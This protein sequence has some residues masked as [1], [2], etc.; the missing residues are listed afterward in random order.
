MVK[1]YIIFIPTLILFM[2]VKFDVIQREAVD[3]YALFSTL[4]LTFYRVKSIIFIGFLVSITLFQ[5]VATDILLNV[6]SLSIYPII[7]IGILKTH[8]TENFQ[9]FM[10]FLSMYIF[11]WTLFDLI[12]H[13]YVEG[14]DRY[15]GPFTSSLH[16]SYVCVSISI[17]LAG[18]KTTASTLSGAMIILSAAISGSRVALVGSLVPFMMSKLFNSSIFSKLLSTLLIIT[19]IVILSQFITIRGFI[20]LPEAE[21]I[22]ISGWIK[23]YNYLLE[24]DLTQYIYGNGRASYGAVG[25]RFFGDK[26]FITESSF[27]MLLYCYGVLFGLLLSSYF[28]YKLVTLDTFLLVKIMILGFFL[29]TP[30]ID[31][32]AILCLNA[33]LLSNVGRHYK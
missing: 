27:I 3:F 13:N 32:V 19:G 5:I 1:I 15:S 9:K 24:A 17:V 16:L 4:L 2:G 20:Y 6:L 8:R 33:V 29:I 18:M 21:Q 11:I 22:R 28:I 26:V 12:T 30:F 14:G 10:F 25:F 7:T 31:S 23:F